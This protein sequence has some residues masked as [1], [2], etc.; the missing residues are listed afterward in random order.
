MLRTHW[1]VLRPFQKVLGGSGL[2]GVPDGLGPLQSTAQLLGDSQ[3]LLLLLD[4]DLDLDGIPAG[5]LILLVQLC[6]RNEPL[7]RFVLESRRG[8]ERRTEEKIQEEM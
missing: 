2:P 7:K 1:F 4:L 8:A 6:L 5:R 3:V